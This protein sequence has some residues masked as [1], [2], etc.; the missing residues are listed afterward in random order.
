M[1][2]GKELKKQEK[3][4]EAR[5]AIKREN[6]EDYI[7]KTPDVKSKRWR[8]GLQRKATK[9][10]KER[11]ASFQTPDYKHVYTSQVKDRK[12]RRWHKF[13]VEGE[14]FNKV[15]QLQ[16]KFIFYLRDNTYKKVIGVSYAHKYVDREVYRFMVDEAFS[17]A[18]AKTRVSYGMIKSF[19]VLDMR[20][21]RWSKQ[22]RL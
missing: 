10:I 6:L 2:K 14:P 22:K 20:F 7:R 8:L 13:E 21:I 9:K 11:K 12:G 1:S 3:A 15:V 17:S 16:M 19:K 18:I 5:E 4:Y